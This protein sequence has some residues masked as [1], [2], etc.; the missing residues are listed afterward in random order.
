MARPRRPRAHG[1]TLLELIV[2]MAVSAAVMLGV[3]MVVNYQQRA[4]Y[5]GNRVRA[6][7]GS[8]RAAL[9]EIERRLVLAGYGMDA[10]LAFD[11]DRYDGPCPSIFDSCDRDSAERPDEIVF[12]HRDPNY[13]VPGTFVPPDDTDPQRWDKEPSGNAWR[14]LSLSEGSVQVVARKETSFLPGQILQAVC[15]GGTSYA[16]FTVDTKVDPLAANGT[17][18]IALL[19][20]STSDPFRRQDS[21]TDACFDGGRARMF[22]IR[23]NRL[24]I[25][26]VSVGAEVVPYLVLDEGVDRDGGGV[27]ESDEIVLAEGIENLQLAYELTSTSLAARGLEAGTAIAFAEGAVGSTSGSGMTTLQFPGT[28]ASG[29]L[30]YRPTSWY[31]YTMGPPPHATRLTDHQANIRAVRVAIVARSTLA[32]PDGSDASPSALFNMSSFP[33][34]MTE[35]K[36]F[37]RYTFQTTVPLRNMTVRSM[38]DF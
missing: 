31:G 37:N 15:P 2:A 33:A 30:E 11:F 13:W 23:R 32:D 26:P 10:P 38:N 6:A 14:I 21:A 8:G 25:R 16:Y 20:S 1:V 27:G 22:L 17:A 3:V 28:V 34:F 4:Y 24:H 35:A 12:F 9:L 19:A 36:G 29:Q 5:N 18:T 7:Q